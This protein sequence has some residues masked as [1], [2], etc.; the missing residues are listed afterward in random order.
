MSFRQNDLLKMGTYVPFNT[1]EP[2]SISVLGSLSQYANTIDT[3]LNWKLR[4]LYLSPL[5]GQSAA[6]HS[7]IYMSKALHWLRG[8]S[9]ESEGS[10]NTRSMANFVNC[11]KMLGQCCL[12]QI[13]KMRNMGISDSSVLN[14]AVSND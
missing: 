7:E 12:L 9:A 5:S 1:V 14:K 6:Q 2:G 8:R 3:V 11:L 10:G 13:D 4:H